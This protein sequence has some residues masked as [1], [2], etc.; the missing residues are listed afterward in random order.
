MVININQGGTN[1]GCLRTNKSPAITIAQTNE[2]RDT[3]GIPVRP[4]LE[5]KYMTEQKIIVLSIK[6]ER[7]K[8]FKSLPFKL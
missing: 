6:F 1:N 4:K 7:N 2:T 5:N 8:L 3:P